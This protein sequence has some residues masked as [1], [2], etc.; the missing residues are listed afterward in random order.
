MSEVETEENEKYLGNLPRDPQ[1]NKVL[2]GPGRPKGSKNKLTLLREAVKEEAENIILENLET[3]VTKACELASRGDTT[4]IK[5]ILDRIYPV[6]KAQES[7]SAGG[8]RGITINI[9]GQDSIIVGAK[10]VD[11]SILEGEYTDGQ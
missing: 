8:S 1:T 9:T 2:A 11:E 5:I 4:A 10:P 3:I 6:H 7:N